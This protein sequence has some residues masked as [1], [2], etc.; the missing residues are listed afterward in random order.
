MFLAAFVG[1]GIFGPIIAAF[2]ILMLALSQLFNFLA[3]KL[4]YRHWLLIAL[5]L[6]D[7]FIV[8]VGIYYVQ[9][10]FK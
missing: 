6:G 1:A 8:G 5:F 7:L 3:C 4:D 10:I 9:E 2:V